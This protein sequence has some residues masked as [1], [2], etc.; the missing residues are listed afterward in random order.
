MQPNEQVPCISALQGAPIRPQ[1][2]IST[3]QVLRPNPEVHRPDYSHIASS[4]QVPSWMK[5]SSEIVLMPAFMAA[6]NEPLDLRERRAFARA[7]H[8]AD[9]FKVEE[10][11]SRPQYQQVSPPTSQPC[12]L[13]MSVATLGTGM[14]VGLTPSIMMREDIEDLVAWI[15]KEQKGRF[16]PRLC[17]KVS[18]F[19]TLEIL[20]VTVPPH[21]QMARIDYYKGK[22]TQ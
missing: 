19:F 18:H 4:G 1:P 7:D 14:T 6:V 8:P 9:T 21:V 12:P 15:V 2:A 13:P 5:V 3:E 16:M 11:S 22:T 17:D 20:A 10:A